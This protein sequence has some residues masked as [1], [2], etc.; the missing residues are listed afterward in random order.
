[1]TNYKFGYPVCLTWFHSI[2]TALG[3][4]AMAA[5]GMFT[6]KKL[7][8]TKSA[9]VAAAYVGFIVFN[10]LSIKYNTVGFYQIAKIM[11]TPVVVVIE[12]FAY[13]KTVSREKGFAIG[14]LMFGITV[15]TVSDSQVSSNPL[16]LVVA[17]AAVLSSALY[18]VWAGSKQKELGVNGNQLLHQVSPSAVAMLAVLIPVLE[19]V[20]SF[21]KREAGTIL[22]FSFSQGAVLWILFSSCLGLV[23][24]LRWVGLSA[25]WL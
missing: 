21:S 9:P 3:M 1:M 20:G 24:T 25:L 18:Q 5:G 14:L 19:P 13:G 6:V 7:P 16:G 10:N 8:I 11:I 17:A 15:A 22:G 2:V 4:L 23:V 12:Y